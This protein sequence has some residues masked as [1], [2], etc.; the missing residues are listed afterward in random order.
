[1]LYYPENGSLEGVTL[2][3]A[4]VKAD[5]TRLT[6]SGDYNGDGSKIVFRVNGVR[7]P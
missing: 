5:S 6:V 7:L 2:T 3:G 4:Y 1:M